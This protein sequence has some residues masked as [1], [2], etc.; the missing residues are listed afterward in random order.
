MNGRMGQP[1]TSTSV[2]VIY[3]LEPM[4]CDTVSSDLLLNCPTCKYIQ[5]R[6][7]ENSKRTVAGIH[8]IFVNSTNANTNYKCIPLHCCGTIQLMPLTCFDNPHPFL[9]QQPSLC[10]PPP[11][12]PAMLIPDTGKELPLPGNMLSS[13]HSVRCREHDSKT[14]YFLIF[15]LILSP[16]LSHSKYLPFCRFHYDVS[17]FLFVIVFVYVFVFISICGVAPMCVPQTALLLISLCLQPEPPF[18]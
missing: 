1:T 3:R 10:P 4:Q 12:R 2:N 11:L 16:S 9:Q 7:M 14:T 6:V 8:D 5:C 15:S 13:D 18:C 17:G